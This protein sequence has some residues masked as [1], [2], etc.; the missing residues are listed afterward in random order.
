MGK[1]DRE[2]P[3]L[4]LFPGPAAEMP[5]RGLYLEPPWRPQG[6]PER[7]FVY[8]DFIA[9]LDGRIALP[10]PKTGTH[11]PPPAIT[12]ARDWRLF[13]EL[14]AAADV[15]VTSGRYIRD[16]AAGSAQDQLPVSDKPEFADLH[17]WRRAQGMTPQPAVA[18]VTRRLDLPIPDALLDSGRPVYVVTGAIED[19]G[20]AERLAERGVRVLACGSD[21]GIDGRA[22]V[23]ALAGAGFGT[24][25]MVAGSVMLDMLL[26]VRCLDRLYLS[27]ALRILGGQSFDTLIRGVPLDPPAR[28]DLRAIYWDAAAS[29]GS[30]Q[31]FCVLD[32]Q[33]EDR[34]VACV[35]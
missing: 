7:P 34:A 1:V 13:Q 22:L 27:R 5:L 15:L 4:R 12:N 3:V 10:D 33:S 6:S 20:Q 11:M 26:A 25:D 18:I 21:A 35:D 31:L 2:R 28:F 24:I 32:V 29:G 16:L 30:D 17:H 8:A 14:A 19:A 23:A 9:S